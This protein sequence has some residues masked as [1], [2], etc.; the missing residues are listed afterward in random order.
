MTTS[1]RNWESLDGLTDPAFFG[2]EPW[3]D[4]MPDVLEVNPSWIE[5]ALLQVP[6]IEPHSLLVV[7]RDGALNTLEVQVEARLAVFESG[8]SSA[9]PAR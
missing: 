6:D 7:R 4:T 2:A 5:H 9:A 1:G 8:R 3:T